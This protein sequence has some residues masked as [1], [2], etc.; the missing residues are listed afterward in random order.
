M[1]AAVCKA[2][3]DA[4]FIGEETGGKCI[5][6]GLS[7][8]NLILPFT[9]FIVELPIAYIYLSTDNLDTCQLYRGVTPDSLVLN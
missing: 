3:S 6:S 1:F 7:P 9:H 8:V 4:V 2:K 5:D